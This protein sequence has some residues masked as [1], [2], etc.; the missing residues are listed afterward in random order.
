MKPPR[1]GRAVGLVIGLAITVAAFGAI[2]IRVVV[3]GTRALAAGDAAAARDDIA[4]AIGEWETAAR[5]YL[6]L[7]PHV[8]EAYRRLTELAAA[9]HRHALAAWRAIRSAALATR[10]LWTPHPE[11]LAAANA[12]IA[13]LASRDPEG[14]V[15]GG[16]DAAARKLWHAERLSRTLGPSRAAVGVSVLGIA[17]FLLGVGLLLRRRG[18]GKVAVGVMIAGTVGWIVGLTAI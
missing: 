4:G 8:D 17:G 13:E 16:P 18:P 7:A 2:A 3:S 6:P 5:W 15:A 12:A 9:D 11:D 10:G 14:A 1:A